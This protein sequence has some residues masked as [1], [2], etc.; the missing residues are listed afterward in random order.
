MN[1]LFNEGNIKSDD[2]IQPIKESDSHTIS[3]KPLGD[4]IKGKKR[5]S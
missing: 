4:A 2:S 5:Y 3:L 1:H